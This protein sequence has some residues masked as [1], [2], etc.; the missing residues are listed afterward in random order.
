MNVE[1]IFAAARAD[2]AGF[3]AE[4]HLALIKNTLRTGATARYLPTTR[5][6]EVS[7]DHNEILLA[8]LIR[9]ELQHAAQTDADPD[10]EE[11][12]QLAEDVAAVAQPPELSGTIYNTIPMETDA[13]AAGHHFLITRY[14]RTDVNL[15]AV[16]FPSDPVLRAGNV[17]VDLSDLRVQMIDWFVE[18]RQ[19]CREYGQAVSSHP[20][21]GSDRSFASILNRCSSGAGNDWLRRIDAD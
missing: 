18:H 17:A 7:A 13:N 1:E 15:V 6:I 14:D 8:G 19:L 3:E 9:H 2:T 11:L 21:I 4:V 20:E 12:H 16:E 5:T 10:L